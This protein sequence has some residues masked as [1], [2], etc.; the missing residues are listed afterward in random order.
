MPTYN[1]VV[2]GGD[3]CGPEVT[4][5]GLKVLDV[6]QNSNADVKFNINQ[7]LLGGASIDATGVPLTDEALK[8]AKEA[9]AVILG[10]IGGPKWGTA[11]VRPEQGIL[12]LRK[13]MGTYGNLRPCFFASESLVKTSPLKEEVCR[14]VNFNIVRELTG[15]IYFGERKE[16]DGSGFAM[17][18]E[19][20][21]RAEIERVTR[22]AAY[23]ALAE[24]PPLPVWSLDKANVMATSRLWRKTVTEVMANEF[25]QLKIGHHLIDSAAM[26][27]VKNPRALNGVIVTSNLFGDIISDEASVIPGSLGL[28]PSAS[29][30]AAPDGKSK[31]N[32]I[33]EPIHGSAPDISGKGIVNPVA[34]IL[35]LGMMLKYSL[36]QPELAKKIDEAVRNVIE[37]GVKTADIGG[38]AKTSEVGDA[39]AA[40]LKKLL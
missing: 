40:E 5:E 12:K 29:L 19:P 28:L 31:C 4:A 6:I 21:S 39:V 33:Y 35:S 9:D 13:E 3:H 16:D 17:D 36:Q 8:A 1:I 2:F 20:Y 15:G 18:T 30:T 23:L 14:G 25:P 27:M 7:Q 10:A 37:S 26:L 32:G 34:M 24:D 38:E 11:A 22:L